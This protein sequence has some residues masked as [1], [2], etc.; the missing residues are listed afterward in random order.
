MYKILFRF[1]ISV[2][3]CVGVYFFIGQCCS[4]CYGLGQK[5]VIQQPVQHLDMLKFCFKFDADTSEVWALTRLF[6]E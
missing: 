3:H 5:L 2:V 4:V 6:S 1:D